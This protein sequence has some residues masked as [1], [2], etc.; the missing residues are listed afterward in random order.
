MKQSLKC[1]ETEDWTVTLTICHSHTLQH[2]HV[3]VCASVYWHVH[4][5]ICVLH[6]SAGGSVYG[7]H[8][9]TLSRLLVKLHKL[10]FLGNMINKC[11]YWSQWSSWTSKT[12]DSV[13]K[14][15]HLDLI[16]SGLTVRLQWGCIFITLSEVSSHINL[17]LISRMM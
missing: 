5:C 1:N 7:V 4:M 11:F 12:S 16:W 8:T 9:V 17:N 13:N 3:C 10:T 14:L 6:V 15:V 2:F